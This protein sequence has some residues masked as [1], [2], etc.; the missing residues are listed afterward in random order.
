MAYATL[1]FMSNS[2]AL[3][4]DCRNVVNTDLDI[5]KK[6][7]NEFFNQAEK[8]M[9]EMFQSHLE[10]GS[11]FRNNLDNLIGSLHEAAEHKVRVT[12][13]LKSLYTD[14]NKLLNDGQNII[15]GALDV[16]PLV[17]KLRDLLIEDFAEDESE[18]APLSTFPTLLNVASARGGD[19]YKNPEYKSEHDQSL[20]GKTVRFMQSLTPVPNESTR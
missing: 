19:R 3:L 14:L 7:S 16:Q 11:T 10:D 4:D 20:E 1:N 6:Q 18:L 17:S 2:I 13:E 15:V 8:Q 12:E 9:P 5:F